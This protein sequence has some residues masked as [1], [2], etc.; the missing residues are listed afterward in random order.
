M[1]QQSEPRLHL[2]ESIDKGQ[3]LVPILA[4][5][6]T[7]LLHSTP[8]LPTKVTLIMQGQGLSKHPLLPSSL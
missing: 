3:A 2:S 5:E 6:M 8:Y 7:M 1:R 4:L